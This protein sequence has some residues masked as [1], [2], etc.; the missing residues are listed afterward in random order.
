MKSTDRIKLNTSTFADN[1]GL[2]KPDS[3]TVSEEIDRL[4]NTGMLQAADRLE[5]S[6]DDTHLDTGQYVQSNPVTGKVET[7]AEVSAV[8]TVSNR[9]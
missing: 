2:P 5:S 1:D 4:R 6:C 3:R 9:R 8:K 7:E